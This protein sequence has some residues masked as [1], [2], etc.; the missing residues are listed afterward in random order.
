ML[1]FCYIFLCFISFPVLADIMVKIESLP[2]VDNVQLE[3]IT[4]SKNPQNLFNIS[5]KIEYKK[6]TNEVTLS[7]VPLQRW[8]ESLKLFIGDSKKKNVKEFNVNLLSFFETSYWTK[9]LLVK[10]IW[11]TDDEKYAMLLVSDKIMFID[12]DAK[13]PCKD[14]INIGSDIERSIYKTPLYKNAFIVGEDLFSPKFE[15]YIPTNK[16]IFPKNFCR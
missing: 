2:N 15:T 16:L 1:K 10:S 3:N 14:T 4:L 12:I 13:Y 11:L 8:T 5:D 9:G 6:L 7:L